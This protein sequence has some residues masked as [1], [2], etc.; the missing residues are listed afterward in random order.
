MSDLTNLTRVG[1]SRSMSSIPSSCQGL[2]R[3]ISLR[4]GLVTCAYAHVCS[5]GANA[6]TCLPTCKYC[7]YIYVLC[8]F[9]WLSFE[10]AMYRYQRCWLESIR[11]HCY[12]CQ[13]FGD[14][15][16]QWGKEV[17]HCLLLDFGLVLHQS[18]DK[19]CQRLHYHIKYEPKIW[20][21]FACQ[22]GFNKWTDTRSW[23][24]GQASQ[25]QAIQ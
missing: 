20:T 13:Y 4:L 15:G 23:I 10:L 19:Y 2:A 5:F 24:N 16:L 22:I 9:C 8:S 18:P 11:N 6:Y 25:S 17:V 1:G 7:K 14:K 21:P 3:S 12:Q